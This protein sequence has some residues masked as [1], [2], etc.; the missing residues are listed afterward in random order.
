[1]N[2]IVVPAKPLARAKARLAAVLSVEERRALTL[3]MLADVCTVAVAS[4]VGA[5]RV[6]ASDEDTFAT[7]REAGAEVVADPTPDAGLVPSLE[8]VSPGDAADV[9]D[10]ADS[11]D[12]GPAGRGGGV[13]VLSSDLPAASPED[14]RAVCGGRGVALAPDRAGGG[15]NA[16]WR[17][18]PRA[19][20][21]A[22]GAGSRRAH[23][24]LAAGA[25]VP[26]RLV[27]RPG[28]A[29]DVDTPDDLEAA[30]N[31]AIGPA[32]RAALTQ[33]GFPNRLRRFA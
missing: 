25:G 4:G 23:E 28:L 9:T 31:A 22:F 2:V 1:M 19:I 17:S 27:V 21:L 14:V 12:S 8:A 15:T 11:P 30:W 3:A 33:L 29:L 5:V 16:L 32:T 20:P 26:F 18:P 7:A 10:A 24:D 6:V 13:L